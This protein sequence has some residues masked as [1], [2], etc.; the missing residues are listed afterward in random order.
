VYLALAIEEKTGE[1]LEALAR[2][3][4]FEPL[5]ME[6]SSFV[7]Q[8]SYDVDAATGHDLIGDAVPKN[9]PDR[10]NAAA[11]LH[12]TARDYAIFL[13]AVLE[14]RG[15][16]SE[17][18]DEML[19]PAAQ[20]Q[21][22]GPDEAAEYLHWGLGWG[23]QEGS[24]G[25]SIWHW[26]DNGVFR[27][28]VLG[29][30]QS[31]EGMVYFTNSR[32][33]HGI[34]EDLLG[35]YSDDVQ[36]SAR[37]LDYARYDDP[38]QQARI[39]V[40]KAMAR[41]GVDAGWAMIEAFKAE[42][43]EPV[44]EDEILSLAGF[45]RN[46]DMEDRAVVLL[47]RVTAMR[48]SA[49]LLKS[50]GMTRTTLGEHE[51]ALADLERALAADPSDGEELQPRIDW[52]REGLALETNGGG[53]TTEDLERVAGQYG[54]RILALEEGVLY[55]AREGATDRT[56]LVP[57]SPTDFRLEG[58]HWFR[59]RVE[60]DDSGRGQAVEGHYADGRVDRTE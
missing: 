34:L 57:L 37:W 10:E 21:G 55:Y 25:D 14:G 35:L 56:R 23:L 3:E 46:R 51:A 36:W 43:G 47:E 52:L 39:E 5:G 26:G 32:V 9:K 11:S 54:A 16:A 31:G 17:T 2:R 45:L 8:E 58:N 22:W 24:G 60:L 27:C 15:L 38:A 44:D 30:P 19:R 59:I 33:G 18:V 41:D 4:V 53:A 20:V 7:W 6:Q 49:A 1:S 12:T 42:T 48:P 50:L 13:A 40:R 28:F 29:M